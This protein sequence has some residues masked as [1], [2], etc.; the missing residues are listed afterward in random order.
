MS[1]PMDWLALANATGGTKR[2]YSSLA[3]AAAKGIRFANDPRNQKAARMIQAM[4]RG[5]FSR[6]KTA[7]YR[8]N[9]RNQT[10]EPPS[11]VP[12]KQNQVRSDGNLSYNINQ[13]HLIN[14]VSIPR[15]DNAATYLLNYRDRD[16][17]YLSGVKLCFTFENQAA[18]DDVLYF[19]ICFLSAK[20]MSTISDIDFFRNA[21][22]TAR[23]KN[24]DSA[25]LSS[26]DRHCMPVNA[27]NYLVH[28][29]QRFMIHSS[30]AAGSPLSSRFVK[31]HRYI[32]INRQIRFDNEIGS[33][34]ETQFRVAFWAGRVGDGQIPSQVPTPLLLLGEHACVAYFRE[35]EAVLKSYRR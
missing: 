22:G 32:P 33:S 13:L 20:N 25:D 7:K 29:H 9:L 2:A 11:Q 15:R 24:F 28:W 35:P 16:V 3:N 17:I 23:S 12:T 1:T 6:R 21:S 30:V 31:I 27:D 34:S 4:A 14:P 18:T 5:V 8:S 10:G 19:N 26:H